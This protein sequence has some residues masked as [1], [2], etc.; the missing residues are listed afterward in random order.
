MKIGTLK[1][2]N[3]LILAP[4]H[5]I[6]CTAFRIQCRQ[7]GAALATTQMLYAIPI[8]QGKIPKFIKEDKPLSIQLIGSEPKQ[9]KEAIKKIERH[10]NIID[11]N[12]GCPEH[13]I[14]KQKMGAWFSKHPDKIRQMINAATN[15]T[16]KP[17]TIKIRSGWNDKTQN[18]LKIGKTAEDAGV[19]AITLH[20]RTKEQRYSGKADWNKIRKLKQKTNIPIIGNGDIWTAEDAKR[21]LQETG[22]DMIMI[23]RAAIG[24][25]HIF[26]QCAELIQNNKKIPE[27]T[28]KEKEEQLKTFINLQKKYEITLTELKQQSMWFCK[29]MKNATN[30]RRKIGSINTNKELTEAIKNIKKQ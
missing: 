24:N 29:G 11:L 16:N 1:L 23:G 26:K 21:M 18:Y 10:A 4:M 22:C 20:A 14:I 17:I 28:D 5:G 12:F 9:I 8:I 3:P 2:K 30:K 27:L 13:N 19:A 25:P 15:A 6:N 7:Q